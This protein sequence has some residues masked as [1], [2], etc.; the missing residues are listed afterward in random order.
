MLV[1]DLH[2][3][4]VIEKRKERERD[5][6]VG[7]SATKRTENGGIKVPCRQL[8][9]TYDHFFAS[10]HPTLQEYDKEKNRNKK[11]RYKKVKNDETHK[12]IDRERSSA[13]DKVKIIINTKRKEKRQA[14]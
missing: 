2:C 3:I 4:P 10:F 8:A 12:Y 11:D 5:W 14:D 6:L 1:S 9:M 7:H 13:I